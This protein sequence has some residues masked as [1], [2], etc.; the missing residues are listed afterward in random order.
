MLISQSLGK[1]KTKY[2][3]FTR[4]KSLTSRL[5]LY[6]LLKLYSLSLVVDKTTTL[7]LNTTNIQ[8]K[9]YEIKE[10]LTIPTNT[11]LKY[12]YSKVCLED[13]RPSAISLG[14]ILGV[15]VLIGVV[16]II[17]LP[18]IPVIVRNVKHGASCWYNK[19]Y[20][21]HDWRNDTVVICFG[22]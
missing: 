5:A 1:M 3:D 14:Y 20:E 12:K 9:L 11:T 17:L 4:Q 19:I 6:R 8:R 2:C 13:D 21:T 16:A 15:G 18:D 7:N 22:F 10:T